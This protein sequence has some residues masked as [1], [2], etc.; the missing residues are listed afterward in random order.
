MSENCNF[1][2]RYTFSTHDAA[3][4]GRLSRAAM[5]VYRDISLRLS[6]VIL[7]LRPADLLRLSI[8]RHTVCSVITARCLT[9]VKR[10]D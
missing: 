9:P 2:P 8:S 1:L 6:T 10:D 7:F 5:P 3:A 4:R